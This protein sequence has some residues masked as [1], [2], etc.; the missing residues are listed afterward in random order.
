MI[1]A[2]DPGKNI[3]VAHVSTTG[4]LLHHK[5]ISFETFQDYPIPKDMLVLIGRGTGAKR[6]TE[7]FTQRHISYEL[8]DE[9]GT[10][11]EARRLYFRDHPAKGFMRLLPESFRSPPELIDDYAA[12]AI[13]LRYLK[14]TTARG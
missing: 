7:V 5:I 12:Y 11:L 10:S 13:A 1:L 3:G 6:L 14:T 8:V 9:T 2:F 4:Q